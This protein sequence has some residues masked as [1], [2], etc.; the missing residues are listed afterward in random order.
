VKIVRSQAQLDS[1]SLVPEIG[2]WAREL[3]FSQ[4][5]IAGIDLSS[6]EPGLLDWLS[7]GFHG[8]MAYMAA[9]GLKRARPAELVPGTVSVLTARMDYLPRDTP[10]GWQA[11]EWARLAQPG[12]GVVSLYARGRDYHKVVRGRLQQLADRISQ[13]VGPLGHRVFTDSAPVLEAELAARSGQGWRGKHT[14]VLNREAGSMFFLGEIYLDLP[15]PAT[16]PVTDHCGSCSSCIDVCPTQAILGPGRLDARRCISY[17][18]IEHA[19]SIPVDL[20]ALIGNRIYGCD[21]CQLACPW[22]KFAQRSTLPDFDARASMG[23][24]ALVDQ[25]GWTE[26]QFLHLTQGS[27]IRR[28]GHARWL[29]NVAVAAGNALRQGEDTDLRQA[30]AAHSDHPSAVVRE[31]VAWA[32]AQRAS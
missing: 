9:H 1:S 20:R 18:T 21:D 24:Q 10:E 31:H 17:L 19:G 12:Q 26:A 15:L 8:E 14:L 16:A 13:T 27:P 2:G 25:I 11:V 29:R 6:A 3:G 5:G 30:L 4:I 7:R 28:I 32:L 23:P 22:N